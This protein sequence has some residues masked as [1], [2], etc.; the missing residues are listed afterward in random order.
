MWGG[1]GGLFDV[2]VAKNTACGTRETIV[3]ERHTGVTIQAHTSQSP[4]PLITCA[5]SQSLA[6]DHLKGCREL[7]G[8]LEAPHK[9]RWQ[10]RCH[11]EIL[12]KNLQPDIESAHFKDT[13]HQT[14]LPFQLLLSPTTPQWRFGGRACHLPP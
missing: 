5:G 9:S 2:A 13:F 12:Q 3:L 10:H 7:P 8:K 14:P 6:L 11:P 1:G 4:F